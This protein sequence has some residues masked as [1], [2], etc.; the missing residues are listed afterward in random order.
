MTEKNEKFSVV[1]WFLKISLRWK[2][3]FVGIFIIVMFTVILF[4]LVL[5]LLKEGK[6]E[7][8]R[9]KLRAVVNSVVSIMEHYERS[10][11]AGAHLTDPNMPESIEDG[12]KK[13]IKIIREM[14]YEKTEYFFIL[15]GDGNMIM[16]PIKP[17]LEGKNMLKEKDPNGMLVF[18]DLVFHSQRDNETFVSYLWKSKYSETVYEPQ[19][20]FARHF[21]QWDWVVCSGVYTQ[22]I[23]ESMQEITTLSAIYDIV[24][25]T[26]AMFFLFFVGGAISKREEKLRNQITAAHDSLSLAHAS[27]WGEMQLAKKIQTALLPE[28]PV[29]KGYE[30]SVYMDPADDVGGDYYDII[31]EENRDWV[32]IGDVSGHG[33]PAG[34]IMMMA[35]TAIHVT[36][37]NNPGLPPSEL[38]IR[39]NDA[40][41]RNI[42]KLGE[43]KYMTMTVI[44]SHAEGRMTFAGLH[45][46]IMIYRK[47]SGNVDLLETRGMWIGVVDDLSEMVADDTMSMEIGDVCLLYTDGITESRLDIEK[48][49]TEEN[50]FGDEKLRGL[51]KNSGTGSPEEIKNKLLHELKG[52]KYN[53]DVTLVIL[54]RTS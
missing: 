38:L 52:Y 23:I 28:S 5:P 10:I 31:H 7:E 39:I 32:V 34:L 49:H 53:D 24:T 1:T 45:Q 9:G 6:L 35:Q 8:R 2:I 20:T 43:D 12:K 13:I 25:A 48:E 19:T 15:D 17:E 47:Q 16:H 51:L 4:V 29:L 40:L 14:R 11:R 50:M 18:E 54:K 36:V 3:N 26:V 37:N 44:A 41:T 22:D 30:V 46:D 33:V 42:K 27:L 21:W